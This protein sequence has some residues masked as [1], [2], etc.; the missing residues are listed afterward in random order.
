[1]PLAATPITEAHTL[2]RWRRPEALLVLMAVAS[3]LAFATWMALLNNFVV[4]RAAFDGFDIGVLHVAREIRRRQVRYDRLKRQVLVGS[5]SFDS[6]MSRS[7]CS[8]HE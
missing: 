6:R 3:P 5:L 2:P 4:E 8:N 7:C 1:M